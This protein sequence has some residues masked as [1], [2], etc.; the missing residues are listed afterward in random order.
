MVKGRA[1]YTWRNGSG[2]SGKKKAQIAGEI[3]GSLRSRTPLDILAAARPKTSPLHEFFT[4]SNDEAAGRY[5]IIEARNLARAISVTYV[6][7]NAPEQKHERAF[8]SLARRHGVQEEYQTSIKVFSNPDLLKQLLDRALQ[9][10]DAWSARY[11]HLQELADVFKAIKRVKKRREGQKRRT[12][13]AIS[14]A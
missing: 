12:A 13:Q 5:R 7:T 10:V 3:L 1:V 14:S 11:D 2:F 6:F 9:E 8:V 4:W